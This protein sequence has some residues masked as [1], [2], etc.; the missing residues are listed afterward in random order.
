MSDIIALMQADSN[1]LEF[2]VSNT[3]VQPSHNNQRLDR[4]YH[5]IL[6]SE[7]RRQERYLAWLMEVAYAQ[8]DEDQVENDVNM[9]F[10]SRFINQ[11]LL[12][13]NT[14]NTT[15]GH[16]SSNILSES[17]QKRS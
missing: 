15:G 14:I 13:P 17:T 4:W 7:L 6:S 2:T 10:L 9:V 12:Q 5:N 3:A 8:G 1:M 16:R 11:P